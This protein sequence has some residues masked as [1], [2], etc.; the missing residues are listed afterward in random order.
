MLKPLEE[1]TH[2][3]SKDLPMNGWSPVSLVWIQSLN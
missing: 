1:N 3:M 2:Y